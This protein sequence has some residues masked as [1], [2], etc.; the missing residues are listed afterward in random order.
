MSTPKADSRRSHVTQACTKCR[1]RRG[2]CDGERPTCGS[3]KKRGFDCDWPQRRDGRVGNGLSQ[4]VVELEAEV[5]RLNS[6]ISQHGLDESSTAA[7][8]ADDAILEQSSHKTE[9]DEADSDAAG[10]LPSMSSRL[11]PDLVTDVHAHLLHCF[12]SHLNGFSAYV[13]ENEFR[14]GLEQSS[15]GQT[16]INMLNESGSDNGYSLMLH[17]CI[18]GHACHISEENHPAIIGARTGGTRGLPFLQA[19][20]ALVGGELERK[21][22]PST[23]IAV[24]L[25]FGLLNDAGKS[26]MA[27]LYSGAL[28]SLC[29]PNQ[30]YEERVIQRATISIAGIYGQVMEGL[31]GLT[32]PLGLSMG[33][34]QGIR[35]DLDRWQDYREPYLEPNGES[36]AM[37]QLLNPNNSIPPHVLCLETL[38]GEKHFAAALST[39]KVLQIFHQRYG[40]GRGYQTFSHVSFSAASTLILV[41]ADLYD[42]PKYEQELEKA[43][44]AL[45][46]LL[47]L[48]R[49]LSESWGLA[50]QCVQAVTEMQNEYAVAVDN[51]PKFPAEFDI[52]NFQSAATLLDISQLESMVFGI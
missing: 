13:N 51:I 45:N 43:T 46:E 19:A 22:T 32:R 2:K 35:N 21:P 33:E 14:L 52:M 44:A 38:E 8:L 34:I 10:I 17:Y 50:G 1:Q 25:L 31:Y 6:I 42:Q 4:R 30:L 47:G 9:S 24:T 5:E 11:H 36:E 7:Q 28:L 3:C 20:L 41:L 48:M 15:S 27:W 37:S 18:L 26:S 39:V 49:I 29:W 12:F 40:M 16:G 23:V